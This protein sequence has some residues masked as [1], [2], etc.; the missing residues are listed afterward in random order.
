MGDV[1][2]QS[3]EELNEMARMCRI[4]ILRMT[5]QAKSG[6]PGGSLSAIDAMVA[7]YGTD[8]RF[9]TSNPDWPDRDRFIM[10]KGHASPAMYSFFIRWGF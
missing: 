4:D 2:T 3:H 9:D 5:H 7:L 10:S 1:A 8:F 6:H